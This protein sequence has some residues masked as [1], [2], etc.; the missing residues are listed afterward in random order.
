MFGFGAY[1]PGWGIQHL[2]RTKSRKDADA[3]L[4]FLSP[5]GPFFNRLIYKLLA[6]NMA[7]NFPKDFIPVCKTKC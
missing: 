7:F 5:S 3:L 4:E 1:P 6:E 2:H